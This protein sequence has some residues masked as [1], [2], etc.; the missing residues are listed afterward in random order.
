MTTLKTTQKGFNLNSLKYIKKI[1][2][3]FY[4]PLLVITQLK[5]LT[6]GYN[7][8]DNKP[9]KN[10]PSFTISKNEYRKALKYGILS[11]NLKTILAF[12]Y[13]H[14]IQ[15]IKNNYSNGLNFG[16]FGIIEENTKSDFM[17]F[18][19]LEKLENALFMLD[20]KIIGFDKESETQHKK[21]KQYFI[22]VNSK[23]GL[24]WIKLKKSVYF[25]L[26]NNTDYSYKILMDKVIIE[27]NAYLSYIVKRNISINNYHLKGGL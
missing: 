10:L 24:Y 22:I 8:K 27:F 13:S 26:K 5:T 11:D 6:L 7:R 4:S 14:K 23:Y 1:S 16:I 17:N 3:C 15:K 9:I 19:V 18:S 2:Y 25:E 20:N 12:Y 21:H